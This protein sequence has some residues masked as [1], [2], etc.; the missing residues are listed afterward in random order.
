MAFTISLAKDEQTMF[1]FRLKVFYTVAK[2]LNFTKASE[3]LFITQPAVSK[4][5]QEI[6]N[7]YNVRLFER[8]GTKIK[9]T[10]EGELLLHYSERIFSVYRAIENEFNQLK[11]NQSASLRIGASTSIAY[12]ILPV[13]L[14]QFHKVHPHIKVTMLTDNTQQ[15][16]EA[17]ANEMI[18]LGITEGK[19]KQKAFK[20]SH[21]LDD[22]IVCVARFGHPLALAEN[23]TLKDLTHIPLLLREVGSGSLE[24]LFHAFKNAGV[25]PKDLTI[26]MRLGSTESIKSYLIHADCIAFLSIHSILNELKSKQLTVIDIQ[27][28]EIRRDLNFIEPIGEE[29]AIARYFTDFALN[30]NVKL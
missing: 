30:H 2:K 21:Y 4:H 9:L 8:N 10:K 26:E 24:V 18:D 6:E 15:I 28:F 1:D 3:E 14:A 25:S 7:Y 19:K 5:I 12:Y 22:E 29:N 17:L 20:Y 16:E 13:V 23:I 27:D 11:I